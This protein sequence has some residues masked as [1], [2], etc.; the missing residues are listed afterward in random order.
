MDHWEAFSIIALLGIGGYVIERK[1][2]SILAVLE[3][4]RDKP[5]H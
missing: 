4:I 5:M 1:L 2:N 3:Q